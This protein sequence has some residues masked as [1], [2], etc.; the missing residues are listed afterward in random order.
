MLLFYFRHNHAP[1]DFWNTNACILEYYDAKGIM[2]LTVWI[3]DIGL[4]YWVWIDE[5][6]GL[7]KGSRAPGGKNAASITIVTIVLTVGI[8]SGQK[9]RVRV[10]NARVKSM[11]CLRHENVNWRQH[12]FCGGGSLVRLGYS[13]CLPWDLAN[14]TA[15]IFQDKKWILAFLPLHCI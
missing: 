12:L 7:R 5:F 1:A 15:V 11:V 10:G 9:G 14:I 6:D 2:P 3:C 8:V 4:S 13:I